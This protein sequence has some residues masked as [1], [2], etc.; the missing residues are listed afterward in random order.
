MAWP[1]WVAAG[2][3]C[4]L[5][6]AGC[7]TESKQRLLRVFFTGTEET[8][9]PPASELVGVV[10]NAAAR[11]AAAPEEPV[12]YMHQ[13]YLE[14]KCDACHLTGQS[15]ELRATGS[16]LCLECH[17]KLIA[18]AAFIHTPIGEGKCDPCH[19]AHQSTERYLLTRKGQEVC[20]S[21]HKLVEMLSLKGHDSM[22]AAECLSCHD[23]H[24]SD[25]K[26]LLKTVQ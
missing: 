13:P 8:N 22:G 14:R 5:L 7:S 3:A 2:F 9:A 6:A 15:E 25:Q 17:Q 19:D 12:V 23:A 16:A 24:R 21:C 20:L 10:T 26:Y 1:R 4:G 11:P 18:N